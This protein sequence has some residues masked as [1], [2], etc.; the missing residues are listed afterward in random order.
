MLG[1]NIIYKSKINLFGC[2]DIM[3]K[4]YYFIFMGKIFRSLITSCA[5]FKEFKS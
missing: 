1:L 3:I 4:W 2:K 5:Q